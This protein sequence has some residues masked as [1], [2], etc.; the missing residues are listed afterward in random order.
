M[1]LITKSKDTLYKRWRL[2]LL[3]A[4]LLACL[5]I[6]WHFDKK[7]EQLKQN[8]TSFSTSKNNVS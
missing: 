1:K 4:A 2:L 7:I 6:W 5:A 8:P 3:A